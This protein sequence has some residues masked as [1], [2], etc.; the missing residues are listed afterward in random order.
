MADGIQRDWRELCAA[1]ANERDSAKLSLLVQEL[2]KAL[3][4]GERIW[5][6]TIRP[7]DTIE[8]NRE[9]A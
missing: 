3:D 9:F 7:S 5:H 2:I 4:E 1:V 8:T 6:H